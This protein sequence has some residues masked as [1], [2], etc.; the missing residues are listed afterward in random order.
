MA[1]RRLP[2]LADDHRCTRNGT[3]WRCHLPR[4]PGKSY[5]Q[6]HHLFNLARSKARSKSHS[7]SQ[8]P[9]AIPIDNPKL[10]EIWAFHQTAGG[11][12]RLYARVERRIPNQ[13]RVEVTPLLAAAGGDAAC[14]LFR[15][16]EAM[17]TVEMSRFSHRV[18]FEV[19]GRGEEV[20]KI[21]PRKGEIWAVERYGWVEMMSSFGDA[22]GASGIVLV[23]EEREGEGRVFRRRLYEEC[24]LIRRFSMEE[25]GMF[26]FRVS[27]ARAVSSGRAEGW[28]LEVICLFLLLVSKGCSFDHSVKLM[29]RS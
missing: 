6:K 25:M 24:E 20:Y 4:L 11:P 2:D 7:L 12:P 23:E 3:N 29:T 14:G 27:G 16:S 8:I 1:K 15:A 17:E 28:L 19:E 10:R 5:C 22:D 9:H 13:S 26:S 18:W 21:F